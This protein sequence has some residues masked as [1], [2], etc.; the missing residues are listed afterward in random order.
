[1]LKLN[2]DFRLI[3]FLVLVNTSFTLFPQTQT[4][5]KGKI[6]D[7]ET[8]EFI[9]FVHFTFEGNKGFISN[10]EGTFIF[11]TP[12][13]SIVQVKA[14]AIGYES[15]YFD[16]YT[17]QSNTLYLQPK[18]ASLKEVVLTYTDVERE[19]IKKVIGNIP[20]NYPIQP[21]QL[22]GRTQEE[23]YWDRLFSQPI[24]K[25]EAN[26]V[27]DKF[28]YALKNRFGNVKL[29][30]KKLRVFEADS[31]KVRFYAGIHNVHR[32]DWVMRKEGPLERS[33]QN[34]FQFTIKDTVFFGDKKVIQ[35]DYKG[36]KK[37]GTLFIEAETFAIIRMD[38]EVDAKSVVGNLS[39]LNP[40]RRIFFKTRT[41]YNRYDDGKWR[42]KFIHYTTAFKHRKND[43]Q[44]FLNNTYATQKVEVAGTKIPLEERVSYQTILTDIKPTNSN[45]L[46]YK[47]NKGE[48]NSKFL[49]FIR[50]LSFLVGLDY[51]DIRSKAY[52]FSMPILDLNIEKLPQSTL[53]K[54]LSFKYNYSLSNTT[55]LVLESSKAIQDKSYEAIALGLYFRN[56]L[57]TRGH[58]WY[59]FNANTGIRNLR[60][61][62]E[63]VTFSEPLRIG[64]ENFDSGKIALY[65]AQQEWF[66]SP[67]IHIYYQL[68]PSLKLGF[69]MSYFFPIQTQTGLF[70]QE[71]NEFWFWN[72]SNVFQKGDSYFKTDQYL[73]NNLKFSFNFEFKL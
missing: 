24:Y 68:N 17:G 71:K 38:Q 11:S 27:S 32:F 10:R 13:D 51:L 69:G 41:E 28:S 19:L 49:R 12:S 55:G 72:R 50:K 23:T 16:L 9:P 64:G 4:Q 20:K 26:T 73:K 14:S 60:R 65:G 8:K 45:A 6:V 61:L 5:Y 47:K 46:V 36:D 33:K 21:E 1:M 58:W 37:F 39:F 34:Q 29:L 48:M 54:V 31:L 22:W 57:S 62:L 35:M 63:V 3:A 43:K 70:V 44:F 15:V 53:L 59:Q 40:Y 56:E 7:A 42:L 52:H 25:A 66:F 67:E 18:V 30:E 2:E